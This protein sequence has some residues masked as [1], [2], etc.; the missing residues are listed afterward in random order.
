MNI[1]GI[2]PN[3][4]IEAKPAIKPAANVNYTGPSFAQSISEVARSANI[5]VAE[6]ATNSALQFNRHKEEL[7]EK[8]YN[9]KEEEEELLEEYL[10][11]VQKM[12]KDLQK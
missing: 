2:N 6:G 8:P 12:L 7:Q 1:Y 11:R 5:Q 4:N 9:F 10:A 3:A